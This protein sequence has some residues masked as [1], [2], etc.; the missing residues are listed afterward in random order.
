MLIVRYFPFTAEGIRAGIRGSGLHGLGDLLQAVVPDKMAEMVVVGLELVDIEEDDRHFALPHDP[1]RG[2]EGEEGLCSLP[3]LDPGQAVGDGKKR[4]VARLPLRILPVV[5]IG[6]DMGTDHPHGGHGNHEEHDVVGKDGKG[7]RQKAEADDGT[8]KLQTC[9]DH[10]ADKVGRSDKGEPHD[11]EIAEAEL[12]LAFGIQGMAG[13]E[14]EEGG[15]K[16]GKLEEGDGNLPVL[17]RER[18]EP[19]D[20]GAAEVERRKEEEKE[21]CPA[22]IDIRIFYQGEVMVHQG[23]DAIEKHRQ[24]CKNAHD[25]GTFLLFAKAFLPDAVHLLLGKVVLPDEV[26]GR[27]IR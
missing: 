26:K 19:G 6:E 15:G 27:K 24:D 23:S 18:T 12:R 25:Q 20:K 14:E 3:V 7:N 8:D 4:I 9:D 10:P 22:Q 5:G 21:D 17:G 16:E 11:P 13:D 1:S 2:L